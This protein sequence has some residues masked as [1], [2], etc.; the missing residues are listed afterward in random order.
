M[1]ENRQNNSRKK[2]AL[3]PQLC[4]LLA[5]FTQVLSVRDGL[6][7]FASAGVTAAVVSRSF[8]WTSEP[9]SGW[10]WVGRLVGAVRWVSPAHSLTYFLLLSPV[11]VPQL[12]VSWLNYRFPMI[13]RSPG[14]LGDHTV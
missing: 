2:F 5:S 9:L 11:S 3:A 4:Y 13:A 6:C 8:N 1:G 7:T 10:W 12:A 14:H